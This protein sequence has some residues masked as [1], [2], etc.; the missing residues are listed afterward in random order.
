MSIT[1]NNAVVEDRTRAI[2]RALDANTLPGKLKI[3]A[4]TQPGAGGTPSGD[5][6]VS[7]TFP[8]PSAD[9]YS[10]GTLTLHE[11]TSEL[12]LMDGLATWARLEDGAGTWVADC[13]CGA[14]GSGHPIIIYASTAYIY[15]GGTVSVMAI[16]IS[17]V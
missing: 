15:A 14:T 5:L 17:E 11:P 13:T 7:M 4:G 1:L 2:S 9:N 16:S 12:A 3:Y 10:T 8:K 6:L